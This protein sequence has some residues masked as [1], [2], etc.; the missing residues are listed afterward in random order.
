MRYVTKD[1]RPKFDPYLIMYLES[2]L[3]VQFPKISVVSC[4]FGVAY[5]CSLTT[6]IFCIIQF[7]SKLEISTV[8]IDI[9][10]LFV[11]EKL[12]HNPL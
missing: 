12:L 5:F 8:T 3:R 6:H 10:I 7:V 9:G 1:V 4:Y 11:G 2:I